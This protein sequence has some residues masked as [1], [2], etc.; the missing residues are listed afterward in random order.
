MHIH[1]SKG[2]FYKYIYVY[3]YMNIRKSNWFSVFD[4]VQLSS[5]PSKQVAT[6]AGN[7]CIDV[8]NI[9]CPANG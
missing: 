6:S 3:I 5:A 7:V 4:I 8:A 1:D 2:K 9:K